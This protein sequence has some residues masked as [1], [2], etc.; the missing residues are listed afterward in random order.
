M[1]QTCSGLCK[2]PILAARCNLEGKR[3]NITSAK[4]HQEMIWPLLRTS[5]GPTTA[6]GL[7]NLFCRFSTSQLVFCP[8]WLVSSEKKQN[9]SRCPRCPRCL[10]PSQRRPTRRLFEVFHQLQWNIAMVYLPI[11]RQLHCSANEVTFLEHSFYS[12]TWQREGGEACISIFQAS[13]RQEKL[14]RLC[15]AWFV[16]P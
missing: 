5:R 15:K 13:D 12:S 9:S 8:W 3:N 16:R 4:S 11:Y 6:G 2:A 1:N 7:A 14:R 10:Q